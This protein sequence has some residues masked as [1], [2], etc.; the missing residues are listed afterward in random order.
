MILAL[1]TIIAIA[2]N[3]KIA[4]AIFKNKT[5]LLF[6]AVGLTNFFC[7]YVIIS[8][9]LFQFDVFNFK[10]TMAIH[11]LFDVIV[12]LSIICI[13]KFKNKGKISESKKLCFKLDVIPLVFAIFSICLSLN[14]F[15]LFGAGQDQGLYQAEAVALVKG[16]FHLQHDFEEYGKLF[17]KEE[18]KQYSDAVGKLVGLYRYSQSVSLPTVSQKDVISDVSG[19][20]HGIVT[21]P[22]LA[23]LYGSLFG[24]DRS[25]DIQTILAAIAVIFLYYSMQNIGINERVSVEILCMLC[26]SPLIIWVNKTAFT[27]VFCILLIAYYLF[28]ITYHKKPL[29]S[30]IPLSA[31]A[32]FHVSFL[33]L[34]PMF[35]FINIYLFGRTSNRKF[36]YVNICIAF[37]L[38]C[39]YSMMSVTGAFYF[40]GN[41]SR[42]FVGPINANNFMQLL[43]LVA[44]LI[45][46]S[47]VIFL[48]AK[49]FG[50]LE[51]TIISQ[52]LYKFFS[53]FSF[54]LFGVMIAFGVWK[55][56][57]SRPEDFVHP[58]FV[59][60]HGEGIKAFFH[61]T[62]YA[63]MLAT[64]FVI[65]PLVTFSCIRHKWWLNSALENSSTIFCLAF[66]FF[67]TVILQSALIRKEIFHYY[68]FSRYLSL[69]IPI[70]LLLTAFIIETYIVPKSK[71]IELSIF[72][73][74]AIL[75]LVFSQAIIR[76]KDDTRLDWATLSKLSE[77]IDHDSAVIFD[78]HNSWVVYSMYLKSLTGADV[79]PRFKNFKEEVN[80]LSKKYS[81]VYYLADSVNRDIKV[82]DSLQYIFGVKPFATV[83]RN[84]YEFWLGG[85]NSSKSFYP[86]KFRPKTHYSTL[87]LLKGISSNRLAYDE[88][89]LFTKSNARSRNFVLSGVS[90]GEENF[91][92]TDGHAS[93]F[94][95]EFLEPNASKLVLNVAAVYNGKQQVELFAGKQ[96]IGDMLFSKPGKYSI[97][98]P[99]ECFDPDNNLVLELKIPDAVSP[100]SLGRSGDDRLLG[101]AIHDISFIKE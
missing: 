61:L 64:G 59:Q 19:V 80:E 65:V 41:V 81:N 77:F 68:Y 57:F 5:I 42:L 94:L 88:V 12:I 84:S 43:L 24:V 55:G 49:V 60:Y 30:V 51:Q 96:K 40:Y 85:D 7:I 62:F 56:W 99:A 36:I 67:Y 69:Y 13:V 92:W 32:Y 97:S 100:K 17:S 93:K 50:W 83:Y 58:F 18:K 10:R 8:G 14:R 1:L 22:A 29:L 16:D 4:Y 37:A 25:F 71:K 27:E 2:L 28:I 6:S 82:Q 101:L 35:W 73:V 9:I 95:F 33:I 54:L 63:F 66:A 70:I 91:T 98:V 26:V 46:I 72:A 75:M 15:G 76:G 90:G 87:Y 11:C 45:I 79:Y 74:S 39:G 89:I 23:A 48:N 86:T 52:Y 78:G 31:F 3:V 34:V 38:L 44:F 21:W 20:Y 53:V 47:S